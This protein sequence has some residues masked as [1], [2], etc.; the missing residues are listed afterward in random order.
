MKVRL[1]PQS[2]LKNLTH[3]PTVSRHYRATQNN[4][5]SSRSHTILR[6]VLV[7][8]PQNLLLAFPYEREQ[9]LRMPSAEESSAETVSECYL[10]DLAGSERL[11]VEEAGANR[12]ETRAINQ[13]LL[14]LEQ[15]VRE[16]TAK[17]QDS[18]Y[19][20]HMSCHSFS[21]LNVIPLYRRAFA[22][23]RESALTKLL[24]PA[25]CGHA[26]TAIICAVSFAASDEMETLNTLE[27]ARRAANIKNRVYR[28]EVHTHLCICEMQMAQYARSW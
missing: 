24:R 22:H 10:L 27:F 11:D 21:I 8:F 1:Q 20:Q 9:T 23:V 4:N 6:L 18:A 28:S 15:L 17:P 12:P 25:L 2:S 3:A 19:V 16:L 5:H 13:S 26:L 7:S 14:A